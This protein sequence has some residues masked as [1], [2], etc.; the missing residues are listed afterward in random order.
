MKLIYLSLLLL[1]S[2]G[3]LAQGKLPNFSFITTDGNTITASDIPANQPI[4]VF[5][6]DPY[7]DICNTQA[8]TTNEG[9]EKL[10]GVTMLWVS[11]EQAN[12][13]T[14]FKNNNLGDAANV[15][16]AQDTESMFDSYFGYS[17]VMSI[18]VYDKN[19]TL[20]EKFTD[21]TVEYDK[22]LEL[23]E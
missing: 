7:C 8:V 2:T 18:F 15:I 22:L 20:V 21:R 6:F 14:S 3:V 4:M 19:H 5:Y 12:E 10:K 17:Q 1:L 11:V 9:Q 13:L 16:V 23:I